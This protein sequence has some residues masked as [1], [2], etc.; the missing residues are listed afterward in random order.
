M[1][2]D[3]NYTLDNRHYSQYKRDVNVIKWQRY[4][5]QSVE[6]KLHTKSICLCHMAYEHTHESIQLKYM[7]EFSNLGYKTTKKQ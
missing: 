4:D 7:Q 3:M 5:A 2:E 1:I 6:M